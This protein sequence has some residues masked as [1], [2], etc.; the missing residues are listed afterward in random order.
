MKQLC[1][2]ALYLSGLISSSVADSVPYPSQN[3]TPTPQEMKPSKDITI[4]LFK[5]HF[6]CL[7]REMMAGVFVAK[8]NK[9]D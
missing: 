6:H 4:R 5:A 3:P 2:V 7:L 1:I 9:S 8:P